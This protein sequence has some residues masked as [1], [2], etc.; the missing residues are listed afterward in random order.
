MD[1]FDMSIAQA[2]AI[3][4]FMHEHHDSRVSNGAWAISN[5]IERAKELGDA[6]FESHAQREQKTKK[7]PR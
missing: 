6:A 7:P 3:A 5:L 1:D 2:L 4:G